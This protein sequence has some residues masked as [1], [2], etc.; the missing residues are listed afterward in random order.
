MV[1]QIAWALFGNDDDGVLGDHWWNPEQRDTIWIRIR[2]W[3]RNPFHNLMFYVPPFGYGRW[4]IDPEGKVVETWYGKKTIRVARS[5]RRGNRVLAFREFKV[6]NVI[7]GYFGHRER[8]NFG[9][10]LRRA[11]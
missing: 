3:F 11:H 7:E 4:D 10:A 6:P 1:R 2:W 5:A 8:G 9:I